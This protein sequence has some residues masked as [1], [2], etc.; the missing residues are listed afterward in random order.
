ML[1]ALAA[2]DRDLGDGRDAAPPLG[3][4]GARDRQPVV[5]ARQ[6]REAGRRPLPGPRPLERPGRPDD[7][8]QREAAARLPRCAG[9]RVR[10]RRPA[11]HGPTCW[12][13]I[14]RCSTARRRSSS[15]LGGNFA[16][17]HAGHRPAWPALA[18]PTHRPRRDE[19]QPLAPV[20]GQVALCCPASGAPRS[21][22]RQPASQFVT[23]EDSMRLVH[24]S[25]G[26]NTGLERAAARRSRSSAGWRGPLLGPINWAAW[27]EDYD[28][29]RDRIAADG[30]GL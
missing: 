22:E 11:P 7:R 12:T 24:G 23:V 18:R 29:I 17:G 1:A 2:H 30:A 25:G 9:A 16:R 15:G 28:P 13:R 20:P 19:T 26:I 5:F 8:H 3:G 27:L 21:T 10:L 4:D 14:G 6:H